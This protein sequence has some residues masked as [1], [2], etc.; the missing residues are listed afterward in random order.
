M[1]FCLF[2]RW[3]FL[4]ILRRA[5]CSLSRKLAENLGDPGTKV[6]YKEL[7]PFVAKIRQQ[8][9]DILKS[10]KMRQEF[11]ANVSHE[12]KTP[13]TAISGYAELIEHGMAGK[14]IRSGLPERSIKTPPGF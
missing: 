13:L 5:L 1:F 2:L 12:L 4:T 8:H 7:A 14:R 3:S 9:E 11:T 6:V 10:A